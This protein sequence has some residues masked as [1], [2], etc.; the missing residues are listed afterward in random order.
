MQS[1]GVSVWNGLAGRFT[2]QRL[3]A[4]GLVIL[5]HI[6]V[7]FMLL[8]AGVIQVPPVLQFR[9]TTIWLQPVA[10]KKKPPQTQ[11]TEPAP[12][13]I[14]PLPSIEEFLR[15]L[16]EA[17]QNLPPVARPAEP[18]FNGLRAFGEYMFNCSGAYYGR[19]SRRELDQCLGQY[20]PKK[21]A[22]PLGLGAEADSIWKRQR[23]QA[24][25]P[26][27]PMEGPCAMGSF[28]SNLGLP[29]YNLGGDKAKGVTGPIVAPS[30]Q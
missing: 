3:T 1:A 8:Q 13:I 20:L 16:D 11:S 30:H 5:L 6:V 10:P 24:R 27:A 15:R 22:E 17:L 25:E 14:A 12:T 23:D 19:L 2:P 29:C 26:E 28:Q 18:A 4:I 9:E 7:L 21:R